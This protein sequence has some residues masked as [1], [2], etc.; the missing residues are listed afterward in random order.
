L[1]PMARRRS[2]KLSSSG[3]SLAGVLYELSPEGEVNVCISS[4]RSVTSLLMEAARRIDE[5][6]LLRKKIGSIDSIPTFNDI[7]RQERRKISLSTL[8]WL[9][10]SKINGNKSIS[11]ISN[12]TG[13]NIYDTS[14]II[15]GMIASNLLTLK[16]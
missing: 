8:E 15:F 10:I 16:K 2:L 4:P 5:W 14:R 7:D 1:T 9:V 12:E 6:K 11:E 3:I 13:I